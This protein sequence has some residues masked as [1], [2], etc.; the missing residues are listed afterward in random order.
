[1][2]IVEVLCRLLNYLGSFIVVS[3]SPSSD[4]FINGLC[5]SLYDCKKNYI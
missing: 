4:A 3:L 2:F 1:M 5:Q